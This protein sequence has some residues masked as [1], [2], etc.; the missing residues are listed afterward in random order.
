MICELGSRYW[1]VN[2]R[3]T[4]VDK[5]QLLDQWDDL[6]QFEAHTESATCQLLT[7]LCIT[8]YLFFVFW[9]RFGPLATVVYGNW[10]IDVKAIHKRGLKLVVG[11]T[12]ALIYQH[13]LLFFL[14]GDSA[15]KC[16]NLM[17]LVVWSCLL[18]Y[19]IAWNNLVSTNLILSDSQAYSWDKQQNDK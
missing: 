17:I 10:R 7:G 8:S 19:S 4:G 12:H 5:G 16:H 14:I 1:L 11:H 18:F 9:H 13:L 6:E 3:S 15:Y 2:V